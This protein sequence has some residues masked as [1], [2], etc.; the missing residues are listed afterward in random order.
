MPTTLYTL[1]MV[2]FRYPNFLVRIRRRFQRERLFSLRDWA[3]LLSLTYISCIFFKSRV[4]PSCA[5]ATMINGYQR[6]FLLSCAVLTEFLVRRTEKLYSPE[7]A[8]ISFKFHK[9]YA[10]IIPNHKVLCRLL[11]HRCYS[12]EKKT[13]NF[14]LSSEVSEKYHYF[15]KSK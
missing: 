5:V 13:N 15:L 6:S 7:V 14:F 1:E 4:V 3:G 11:S 9:W 8:I 10:L 12:R 2:R